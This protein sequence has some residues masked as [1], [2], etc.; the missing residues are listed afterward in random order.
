[1][2]HDTLSEHFPLGAELGQFLDMPITRQAIDDFVAAPC[3]D[4]WRERGT[5]YR[6]SNVFSVPMGTSM[7][8]HDHH[9]SCGVTLADGGD[10]ALLLSDKVQRT[11]VIDNPRIC[12]ALG[13]RDMSERSTGVLRRVTGDD[14]RDAWRVWSLEHDKDVQ[15]VCRRLNLYWNFAVYEGYMAQKFPSWPRRPM[16]DLPFVSPQRE[17]PNWTLQEEFAAAYET[18][19]LIAITAHQELTGLYDWLVQWYTHA[20]AGSLHA[21]DEGFDDERLALLSI[22]ARGLRYWKRGGS[23]ANE[24][25]RDRAERQRRFRKKPS[26]NEDSRDRAER[27]RRFRKKPSTESVTLNNA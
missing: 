25:S 3:P 14:P 4:H 13:G 5:G 1:M 21:A 24:D 12:V 27:Q 10:T 11:D 9:A 17:A 8:G 20:R 26:T 16:S 2:P 7:R 22:R 19:H 15:S 23:T 6:V 18:R